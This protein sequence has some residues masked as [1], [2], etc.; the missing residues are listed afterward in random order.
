MM[1]VQKL[2][3]KMAAD[4]TAKDKEVES[5]YSSGYSSSDERCAAEFEIAIDSKVAGLAKKKLISQHYSSP[6]PI[7]WKIQHK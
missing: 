4:A 1:T 2:N 6:S 7:V 5:T 3:K